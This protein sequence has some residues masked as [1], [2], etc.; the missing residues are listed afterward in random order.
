MHDVAYCIVLNDGKWIGPR[1]QDGGLDRGVID[2]IVQ[3][4]AGSAR[5]AYVRVTEAS[6]TVGAEIPL[7]GG[8]EYSANQNRFTDMPNAWGI[9]RHFELLADSSWRSSVDKALQSPNSALTSVDTA[10]VD[11]VKNNLPNSA[12][13]LKLEVHNEVDEFGQLSSADQNALLQQWAAAGQTLGY[14]MIYPLYV[15]ADQP[16]GKSYDSRAA[17][18]FWPQRQLMNRYDGTSP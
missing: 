14:K 10:F 9:A 5:P 8:E 11:Y 6:A 4:A 1:K 3:Q 18:T 15:G 7:A 12:P 17:G 13:V 16:T 2:A